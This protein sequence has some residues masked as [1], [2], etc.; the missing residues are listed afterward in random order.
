MEPLVSICIPVFNGLKYLEQ[1]LD[2]A[3]SQSYKN[4]EIIIVDDGSTD[5]SQ[6]IIEQYALKDS[7]IK[8][9]FNSKN[10]GLTEN[11]NKCIELSS[12]EW[13]KFLF[14]DDY[15]SIDCVEKMLNAFEENIPLIVCKRTFIL[16][17][18]AED[19][20]HD[21][22]ENKVLTFEKLGITD[23]KKIITSAM[24]SSFACKHIGMNFI[25]EPTSI[26]F[27]KK[28]VDRTGMFNTDL[29][30]ICDL[31]F[32]LRISANY[33]LI[34]INEPLTFFRIHEHSATSKNLDNKNYSL[35]HLDPIIFARQLMYDTLFEK[36]RRQLS[37]FNRIKLEQFFALRVYEAYN[38]AL[39]NANHFRLYNDTVGKFPEI[40]RIQ[41]PSFITRLILIAVLLKRKLFF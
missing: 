11:W 22:Y 32:A 14:Q 7:R 3:V 5:G 35:L 16:K 25:G 28:I 27:Q 10:S 20:Q 37:V 26:M 19:K 36:L 38:S 21:Y 13:I 9:I 31:E 8:S 1:C 30:Q 34:Y 17:D 23:I 41:K 24:I 18:A 40:I 2:S 15:L 6:K 39:R 4:I 29:Q 33:G 12:G